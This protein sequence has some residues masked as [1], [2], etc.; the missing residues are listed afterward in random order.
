M[1][2]AVP[3]FNWSMLASVVVPSQVVTLVACLSS[4]VN[5]RVVTHLGLGEEVH[6]VH[7]EDV[8]VPEEGLL[9]PGEGEEGH[10]HGDAHVDPHHAR[11]APPGE[12]P[13][14]VAALGEDARAVGEAARRWLSPA[15]PRRSRSA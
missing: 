14:V 6:P 8:L 10:R 15:P 5:Q 4:S 3:C 2:A 13:R 11:V 1:S 7:P 12:L 9:V